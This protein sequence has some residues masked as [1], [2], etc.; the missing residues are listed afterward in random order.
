MIL[1]DPAPIA[2]F[3]SFGDSTLDL[4]LRCY[5]PD[6][7]NRLTTITDLH[8]AIDEQFNKAGIEIAFPQQDIH[9]RTV[10]D[11]IRWSNE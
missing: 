4:V 8:R 3:E 1:D 7:E 10:E 11:K 5:L 9:I 2:S 6:L